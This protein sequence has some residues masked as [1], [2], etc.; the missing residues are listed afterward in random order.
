TKTTCLAGHGRQ[1]ALAISESSPGRTL[2][3]TATWGA[4]PGQRCRRRA[5]SHSDLGKYPPRTDALEH[6]RFG[7]SH[8]A[9]PD[10]DQPHLARLRLATSSYRDF[11]AVSRPLA[12]RESARHCGLVYEPAR[13]RPGFVPGREEPDS[14]A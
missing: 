10:D 8:R 11:Q 4:A 9:E 13:S 6:A 7:Q 1:V 12:D 2:R 3:R 14:G 5:G